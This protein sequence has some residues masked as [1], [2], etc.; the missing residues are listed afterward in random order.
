M[1][2]GID[3][4]LSCPVWSGGECQCAGFAKVPGLRVRP[5]F[6]PGQYPP[7]PETKT[8][9][10][11]K[12]VIEA[13]CSCGQ[14]YT[15]I[16]NQFGI[17]RERVR[18]I[19]KERLGSVRMSEMKPLRA[20]A[21]YVSAGQA[22]KWCGVRFCKLTVHAQQYCSDPCRRESI[23]AKAKSRRQ[24]DYEAMRKLRDLGWLYREIAEVVGCSVILVQKVCAKQQV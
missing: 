14:S 19:V 12:K 20:K 24:F 3:H 10:R 18:Q 5:L 16:G 21:R 9:K 23:R 8:E 22:C 7:P 15:D 6:K 11:N 13:F 17:C 4:R 2:S 1:K